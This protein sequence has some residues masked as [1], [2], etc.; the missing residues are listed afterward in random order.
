MRTKLIRGAVAV[1]LATASLA[2]AQANIVEFADPCAKA[3]REFREQNSS[4]ERQFAEA[5]SNATGALANEVKNE[6]WNELRGNLRKFYDEE[7]AP[8]VRKSGFEPNNDSFNKWSSAQIEAEGGVAKIEE[9]M[10]DAYRKTVTE[11]IGKER[12]EVNATITAHKK[13][14]D[15]SCRMDAG[16]T[17]FRVGVRAAMAPIAML[18]RNLDGAKREKT[19]IA[20]VIR[21]GT[22]ISWDNIRK[23]GIAGGKNSEPRKFGRTLAKIGGW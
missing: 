12:S 17:V 6:L 19:A 16:N 5:E 10:A 9:K 20:K 23:H 14:L 4:I 22:G 11:E 7:V 21:A 18:G 1:V 8:E 15:K 2:T 13:E 3:R